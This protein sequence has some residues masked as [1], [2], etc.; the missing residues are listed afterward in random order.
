MKKIHLGDKGETSLFNKRVDKTSSRVSAIGVV[1]ELNSIIGLV[2]A[3]LNDKQLNDLIEKVQDDLFVVGSDLA[4]ANVKINTDHLQNLEKTSDELEKELKP[5]NKFILPT[6]NQA[7]SLL[8]VARSVCRRA[9]REI[10]AASKE[11]KINEQIIPYIN[12]LSDFLFIL[13]RV[14]N[15]RAGVEEKEW[16]RS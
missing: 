6:G 11:E 8:H 14:V 12:R 3:S 1:D 9:E 16:T 7:A 13:A 4:N 15:K 2:R 10:V 5:L